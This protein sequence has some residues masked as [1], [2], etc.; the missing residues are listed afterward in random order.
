VDTRR[1]VV[2]DD[3]IP[4]DTIHIVPAEDRNAEDVAEAPS[5]DFTSEAP[6]PTEVPQE[7]A[8]YRLPEPIELDD[9]GDGTQIVLSTN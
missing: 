8:Q 9:R 2:S 1:S 5:D 4:D 6:S 7:S 3:T